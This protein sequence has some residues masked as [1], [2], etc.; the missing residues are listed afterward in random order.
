MKLSDPLLPKWK[1]TLEKL[2]P[3]PVDEKTG[4]MIGR[5]VPLAQSHRHFS[6]LLMIYP[7]YLMNWEQPENRALIEK[8][9]NHWIG[10]KGALQGYSYTGAAAIKAQMGRGDE[11]AQLLNQFLDSYVKA[12]TMYLEAG[13]VIETPL[14]GA[15]TLHE[16]LLQSWG[17]KIRI[18]P[19]I[20]AAWRDVTIHNMRAEGAFLV[21]A[22]RRDG[23]TQ[24]VRITSL[25]GEPCRVKVPDQGFPHSFGVVGSGATLSGAKFEVDG[26]LRIPLRKGHT[27]LL[28]AEGVSERQ[29]VVDPVASQEWRVNFYGSRKT[30]AVPPLAADADG[31][32]TLG[33]AQAGISGEDLFVEKKGEKEN[34]G[35]WINAKDAAH[36]NL[37][38]TTPGRY[39]VSAIYSSPGG[40]N[41]FSVSIGETKLTAKTQATGGFE[42][43][44]EFALGEVEMKQLGLVEVIVRPEGALRGALMNL[45]AIRLVPVK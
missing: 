18:F 35:H 10:F 44:Q 9:L 37:K 15:A 20:P 43:F 41:T 45:Q 34:L 36:W 17:G 33:A 4:L 1:E 29:V 6:H 32:F 21:S 27:L 12:N 16:M 23:K 40:G 25:A 30:R 39:K 19:A 26:S 14:A 38:A 42:K 24:W 31:S 3:Y 7:L 8:S 22:V 5:G 2:T 11:A 13:P 28:L